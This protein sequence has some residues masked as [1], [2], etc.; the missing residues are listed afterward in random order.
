MEKPKKKIVN[1]ITVIAIF[2]TLSETSA[3]ATLPFLDDEERGVYLWFLITFPFY[4]LL[5]FFATLNFNYRA[6]YAPSDYEKGEH[7]IEV[8][9]DMEQRE[10]EAADVRPASRPPAAKAP[11][12]E[13]ATRQVSGEP[14][15]RLPES[16]NDLRIIDARQINKKIELGTLH[17]ESQKPQGKQVHVVLFIAD[18]ESEKQLKERALN[19]SKQ[20]RKRSSATFFVIYNLSSQRVTVIN[21]CH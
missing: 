11:P 9:G 17:Q 16:A 14:S 18:T 2:A 21:T 6:L 12:Q 10:D 8:L 13:I 3:V 19:L 20:A 1:P 15:V 5:L 7:F 4:L